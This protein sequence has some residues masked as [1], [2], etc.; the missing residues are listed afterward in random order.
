MQD[1]LGV[2]AGFPGAD[3]SSG[4]KLEIR[5]LQVEDMVSEKEQRPHIA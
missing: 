5:T 1:A 4:E 2:V 3:G